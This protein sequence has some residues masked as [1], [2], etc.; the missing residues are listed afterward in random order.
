MAEQSEITADQKFRF[1]AR[2]HSLRRIS[3]ARETEQKRIAD[4]IEVLLYAAK[5][6]ETCNALLAL[7]FTLF[8]GDKR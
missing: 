7:A 4:Q 8:E 2:L 5:S 1:E 6:E 3:A